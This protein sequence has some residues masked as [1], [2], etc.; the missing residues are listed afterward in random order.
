[1][2]RPIT[3][4][5]L[6]VFRS[7]IEPKR[8]GA[9]APWPLTVGF[10]STLLLVVLTALLTMAFTVNSP[11]YMKQ[12]L[13]NSDFSEEAYNLLEVNYR[14]Y[15]LGGNFPQ[16]LFLDVLSVEKIDEDM[17]A[18]V[19][20]LY[21][22]D[23]EFVEYTEV[24]KALVDTMLQYADEQG[25]TLDET[26]QSGITEVADYSRTDYARYVGIPLMSQLHTILS[27]VD[28]VIWISVAI[29]AVLTA[30]SLFLT[31]RLAGGRTSGM[32]FLAYSFTAAAVLCLLI[33]FAV[34]PLLGL[35]GLALEPISLK[36][37]LLTYLAGIF[38][39]FGYFAIVYAIAAIGLI[40]AVLFIRRARRKRANLYF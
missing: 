9:P 5:D 4:E 26:M 35:N 10:L 38:H 11:A 7:G 33:A 19:D 3:P 34:F 23:T 28:R 14:S 29:L 31:Y 21:A 18:A 6:L 40:L 22:G 24:Q 32:R 39:S 15:A 25:V 27:K 30:A 12:S 8:R 1:M 17:N 20:R 36:A 16:E 2:E 13:K 37:F